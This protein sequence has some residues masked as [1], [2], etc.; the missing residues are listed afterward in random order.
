MVGFVSP[1]Y[2]N[3]RVDCALLLPE[4]FLCSMS[5]VTG[6]SFFFLQEERERCHLPPLRLS[7]VGTLTINVEEASER[8][9]GGEG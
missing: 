6:L 3:R 7:C 9:I 2:A 5:D 4:R 8:G 1:N